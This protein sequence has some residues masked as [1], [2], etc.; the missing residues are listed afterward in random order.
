MI[1]FDSFALCRW[2]TNSCYE[3]SRDYG[4]GYKFKGCWRE[5]SHWFGCC[6]SYFR[7]II[8]HFCNQFCIGMSLSCHF[9][10]VTCLATFM[11]QIVKREHKVYFVNFAHSGKNRNCIFKENKIVHHSQLSRC[12][13]K[14]AVLLLIRGWRL[15]KNGRQI[16]IFWG[17]RDSVC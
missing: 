15:W 10:W 16:W 14:E 5:R 8:I 9:G 11:A 13:D 12:L 17:P 4:G 3:I 6:R 1:M 2:L 7:L